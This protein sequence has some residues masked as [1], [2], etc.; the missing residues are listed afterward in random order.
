MI[1]C[2]SDMEMNR[3]NVRNISRE[4]RHS[5]MVK[6]LS[7]SVCN[8]LVGGQRQRRRATY[9]V[10]TAMSQ[11]YT[12][13]LRRNDQQHLFATSQGKANKSPPA[14]SVFGEAL[15]YIGASDS[16]TVKTRVAFAIS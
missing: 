9:A 7:P 6:S 12:L 11:I 1:D 10:Y 4:P 13:F 14:I 5:N 8:Q 15:V 2:Y 16:I 3:P